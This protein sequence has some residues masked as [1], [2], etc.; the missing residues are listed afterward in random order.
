MNGS[1]LRMGQENEVSFLL[2]ICKAL[3][4]YKLLPCSEEVWHYYNSEYLNKNCSHTN[5]IIAH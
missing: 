1:E 5:S 4:L 3:Q 2:L